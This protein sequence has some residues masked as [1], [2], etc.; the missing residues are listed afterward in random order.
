MD[1]KAGFSPVS[2]AKAR[3]LV[4]GSFPSIRSLEAGQYYA[5]SR[6]AFWKIIGSL[7][8]AKPQTPY[9]ERLEILKRSGIA[10]WDVLG[11]CVRPGSMDGDIDEE[12]SRPNDF[13]AFFQIN[14]A[15]SRICF[16]GQKAAG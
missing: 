10:L 15:I 9:T 14:R 2:D 3:V 4:L 11:T 16:N 1:E 5:H 13:L 8:G 6:N 7:F 12:A